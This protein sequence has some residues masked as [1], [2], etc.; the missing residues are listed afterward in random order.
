MINSR[1]SIEPTVFFHW[2][3]LA[4]SLPSTIQPPGKR[5]NPGFISASIWTISL[6]SPFGRPF[7]VS[8]GNSDSI[9]TSTVPSPVNHIFSFALPVVAVAC[10]LSA[11]SV[12]AAVAC[13]GRCASAITWSPSSISAT[14]TCKPGALLLCCRLNSYVAPALMPMPRK[15][16]FCKPSLLP[17]LF[18]NLTYRLLPLRC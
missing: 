18:V 15:P 5:I 4:R 11:V 1:S 16:S 17:A 3:L 8:R 14:W 9:S 6:R 13:S 2:N 10:S 7:Q 12:H